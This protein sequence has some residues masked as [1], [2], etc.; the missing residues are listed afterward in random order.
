MSKHVGV[1][2]S[3]NGLLSARNTLERLQD[4]VGSDVIATRRSLEATNL[5]TVAVAV[6]AAAT[7]RTESRGCHRRT[8]FTEALPEWQ[9][10]LLVVDADGTIVAQ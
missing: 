7:A 10:H 3:P 1:L 6:V 4:K 5:L 8:D 2:R 9:R